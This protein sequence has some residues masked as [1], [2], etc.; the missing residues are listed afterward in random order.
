LSSSFDRLFGDVSFGFAGN[1]DKTT[2]SPRLKVKVKRENSFVKL[3][4]VVAINQ[5]SE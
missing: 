5:T 3:G 1:I 4:S 2:A